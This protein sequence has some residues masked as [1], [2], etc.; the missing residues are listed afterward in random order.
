MCTMAPHP[1]SAS[2]STPDSRH[3]DSV[4]NRSSGPCRRRITLESAQQRQP[5]HEAVRTSH[6][7]A[8][9]HEAVRTSH[10]HASCAESI[11]YTNGF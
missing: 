11:L 5:L 4:S 6:Q 7:Y 9:C 8:S 10:Q 1:D 3:C 2:R